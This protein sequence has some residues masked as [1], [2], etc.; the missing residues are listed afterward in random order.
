MWLRDNEGVSRMAIVGEA[1]W[2]VAVLTTIAQPVRRVPIDYFT[3]EEA[4]RRWLK[5]PVYAPTHA[6]HT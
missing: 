4:A 5:R 1:G 3:T 6:A 2:R